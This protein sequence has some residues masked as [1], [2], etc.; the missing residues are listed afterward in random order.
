MCAIRA[1]A[2][3]WIRVRSPA[4]GNVALTAEEQAERQRRRIRQSGITLYSYD[5]TGQRLLIPLGG[6]LYVY[7]LA[8]KPAD[9]VRRLTSTDAYE[10]DSRFSPRSNFVSFVRDKNLYV[11]DLATGKERAVTRDGG[12]LVSFGVAEFIA[13]EEMDRD[14]GLVLVARRTTYRARPRRRI[15][16]RRSRTLEIRP[17]APPWYASAIRRPARIMRASTCSSRTWRPR[18]ASSSTSEPMPTSIYL[19]SSGSLT[20]AASPCS[21]RAATR[22]PWSCCASMRCRA[23][24]AC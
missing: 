9:A 19:T 18:A 23:A 21:A 22:K 7:D 1:I 20:A 11:I 4:A 5:E 14:T 12:G 24:A 2:C 15:A 8:R 6:D 17:P 10:T 16:R 13:Q 3:W